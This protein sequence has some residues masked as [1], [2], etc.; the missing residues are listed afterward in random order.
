[1]VRKRSDKNTHNNRH[2]F[3]IACGEHKGKQLGFI[4]EFCKRDDTSGKKN[5]FH[6]FVKI[7]EKRD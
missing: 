2:R 3:P 6:S 4:S 1:M 7:I 5:G